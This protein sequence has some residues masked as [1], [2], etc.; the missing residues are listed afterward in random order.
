M[1]IVTVSIDDQLNQARKRLDEKGWTNAVNTWAGAG[2]WTTEVA[3][4]F[5][6]TGIPVEYVIGP[7]GRIRFGG[8]GGLMAGQTE[9]LVE[10]ALKK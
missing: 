1:E 4:R 8:T 5:R 10:N 2:G 7:E 3:K 6:V 9:E